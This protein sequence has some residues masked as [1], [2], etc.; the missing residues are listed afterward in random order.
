MSWLS[1]LIERQFQKARLKGDLQNLEG[2]GKP[3][4]ERPG[5]AFVEPGLAAGFRVMAEAGVVPEEI[6]LK[7]QIAAHK[8]KM[9]QVHEPKA[10]KVEM[11]K[12]ADLEMRLAIAE[13]A[14]RK[15]IA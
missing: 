12:L 1:R 13:E 15:F 3:L 9:V 11:R 2:E 14:R 7:K 4:P 6:T 8:A 10:R 5:D